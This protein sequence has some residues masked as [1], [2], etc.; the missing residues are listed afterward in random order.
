MGVMSRV[1]AD[2]TDNLTY[3]PNG[4]DDYDVSYIPDSWLDEDGVRHAY[5]ADQTL[6]DRVRL[7]KVNGKYKLVEEPP[8]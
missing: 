5:I 2:D 1:L 3:T 6:P 8:F 4:L 7:E